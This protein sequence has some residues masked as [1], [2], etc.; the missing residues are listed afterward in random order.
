M[1]GDGSLY[2]ADWNNNTIRK[3]M[4]VGTNWVSSTIAGLAGYSGSTD[5]TNSHARFNA[6]IGVAVNNAGVLYV[7]D[8]VN[9]KSAS[10][11]RAGPT[12]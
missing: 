2:V 11:P 1:N 4:P 6:P 7:A 3:L 9:F 10:S 5:G 12:G 8:H